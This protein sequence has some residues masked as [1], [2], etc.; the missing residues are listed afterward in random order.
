MIKKITNEELLKDLEITQREFF[1]YKSISEGF[2]RL[3]ILH[4]KE[5]GAYVRFCKNEYM[6]YDKKNKECARLLEK[7]VK[8]K[9]ERGI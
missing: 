1:A 8:I 2:E 6:K 7:I 5:G 3:Y 9:N 4:E